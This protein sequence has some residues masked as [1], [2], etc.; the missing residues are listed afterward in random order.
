MSYM[1]R[2]NGKKD[3]DSK[4]VEALR[5]ITVAAA[6]ANTEIGTAWDAE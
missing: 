2:A 1:S 5:E 3:G 6:V 4:S